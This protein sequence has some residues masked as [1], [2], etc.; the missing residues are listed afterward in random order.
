[1]FSVG[2]S[3]GWQ[4]PGEVLRPGG[5]PPSVDDKPPWEKAVSILMGMELTRNLCMD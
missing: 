2:T 3:R 4:F 1:M 5:P